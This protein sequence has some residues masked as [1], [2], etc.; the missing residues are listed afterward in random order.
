[1]LPL[2]RALSAGGDQSDNLSRLQDYLDGLEAVATQLTQEPR[3]P[4]RADVVRLLLASDVHDNVFGMR[5]AARLAAGGG[6]PVDGV[7]LA[8]DITDIGA[9]ARRRSSSCA[10]S[11]AEAPVVLVGGNHEDAPAMR[12]FARR[13]VPGARRDA[14]EDVAGV[15]ILGAPTRW[16]GRRG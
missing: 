7:L 8:G 10:S 11:A 3:R 4:A 14:V 13:R 5:A 1:M 12:V 16:L 9:G 15:R 6:D 2:L